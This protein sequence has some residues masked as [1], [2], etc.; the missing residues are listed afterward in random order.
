MNARSDRPAARR[1]ALAALP[2][3]TA[4]ATAAHA[5]EGDPS[6][7]YIGAGYLW[8]DVNYAVKQE[9][10]EHDGI[11]LEASLGLVDIGPVGIHLYG[12]YFDGNFDSNASVLIDGGEGAGLEQV[13]VPGGDS[14]GFMIGIGGSYAVTDSVDIVGRVLYADTEADLP[15]SEGVLRAVDGDGYA[16]Q[17][18]VRGMV[19]ERVE[20]EAGFRYTDIDGSGGL[21]SVSNNDILVGLTYSILPQLAVRARA[22]IFDDDTGLELGARWYFGKLY[23]RDFLF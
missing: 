21:D 13:V 8:N 9:G 22:I 3:L 19:G 15:D 6:Y 16:L 11:N 12:E 18:L 23:G 10:G 17:A 4:G 20:I 2:L 14:T 7:T 1:L 5:F